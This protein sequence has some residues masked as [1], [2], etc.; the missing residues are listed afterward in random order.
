MEG[1][2]SIHQD[3]CHL[4]FA[5]APDNYTMQMHLKG[6]LADGTIVPIIP[7]CFT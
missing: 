3:A 1:D 4:H 2:V 6:S 7:C 5:F